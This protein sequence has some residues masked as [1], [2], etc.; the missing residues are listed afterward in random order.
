MYKG[1]SHT[2]TCTHAHTHTQYLGY[3]CFYSHS[4]AQ[5]KKALTSNEINRKTFSLFGKSND[6]RDKVQINFILPF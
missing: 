6:S 5:K 1:T 4:I 2:H 3:L